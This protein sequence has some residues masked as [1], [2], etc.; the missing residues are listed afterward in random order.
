M[1]DEET[2]SL[3]DHITGEAFK[4]PLAGYKLDAWPISVTTVAAANQKY[5]GIIHIGSQYRSPKKWLFKV[6]NRRKINSRGF[7]PPLFRR[8]MSREID[9]RLDEMTQGLGVIVED[10]GK[11]YP[12]DLIP[13]GGDIED[14]WRG[15]V[16]QI[17]RHSVDGIPFAHWKD[18]GSPPMQLFTRWY[19]FSFTYPECEIYQ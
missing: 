4:G 8:S 14:T 19:G 2:W 1:T 15:R 17:E 16:L 11:F 5:P 6:I 9:N 3:W 7:L 13:K 10:E 18:T 12:L